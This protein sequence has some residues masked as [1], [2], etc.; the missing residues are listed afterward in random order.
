MNLRRF[1]SKTVLVVGAGWG[2]GEGIARRFAR[3]G[4]NVVVAGR[5]LSKLERVTEFIKAEGGSVV[6]Y[7][8][9]VGNPDEIRAMVK[10]TVDT[11]GSIDVLCNNAQFNEIAPLQDVSLEGWNNTL[12]IIL[13]ACMLSMQ[14]AYPYMKAQ[15]GGVII[16]TGS[17][18]GNRGD[19]K[20]AAYCAAKAGVH[21]L[22]RAAALDFADAHIRVNCVAPGVTETPAIVRAFADE[23]GNFDP[24]WHSLLDKSCPS[25]RINKPEDIAAMFAFLASD[26]ACQITGQI[27]TVDGGEG[28]YSANLPSRDI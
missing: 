19:R 25:G 18:S 8:V 11:F 16:N 2:I 4:A 7:A 14:A 23:N 26:D 27:I 5:T 15:N 6:S 1:E 9:D 21:N 20:F 17:T 24:Y 12:K 10:F 3:E 13:T 28:I 22:T